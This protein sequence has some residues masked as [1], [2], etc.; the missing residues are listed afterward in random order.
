MTRYRIKIV[1]LSLGV[2]L[3]YGSAFAY[4]RHCREHMHGRCAQPAAAWHD[5]AC[6]EAPWFPW[7]Q[8][9]APQTPKPEGMQPEG[10]K[11]QGAVQ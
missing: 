2:V 9:P 4:A 1:L 11:P 3:G 7:E 5:P 6:H 8:R 10:T